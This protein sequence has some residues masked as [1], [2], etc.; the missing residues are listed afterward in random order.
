M[1]VRRRGKEDAVEIDK[2]EISH[3]TEQ[4]GGAWG[5]N[6]TRRLL[7]LIEC[8]GQGL[9]YNAEALWVAAH[10][11]DWGA[12]APW[13]QNDTDHALRSQ[14]VAEAFLNKRDYPGEFK[15]LVL[16]CIGL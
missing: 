7:H 4:Y 15:A 11:H 13:A 12:Y 10:L 2:A 16:E 6:H 14:Q 9:T 8:I 3:L 1:Q 5:I